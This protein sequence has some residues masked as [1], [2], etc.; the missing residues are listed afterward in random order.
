MTAESNTRPEMR[1]GTGC[2]R[3]LSVSSRTSRGAVP[4]PNFRQISRPVSRAAPASSWTPRR[5][6]CSEKTSSAMASEPV[7][8]ASC[9][10]RISPTRTT[11]MATRRMI[12]RVASHLRLRRVLSGGRVGPTE[13]SDPPSTATSRVRRGPLNRN[14]VGQ[15]SSLRVNRPRPSLPLV[16]GPGRGPEPSLYQMSFLRCIDGGLTLSENS[17]PPPRVSHLASALLTL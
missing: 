8:A 7:F 2:R 17:S 10:E 6:S 5:A 9:A 14:N 13:L 1:P 4:K 15:L 3:S 11:A 12:A 16:I